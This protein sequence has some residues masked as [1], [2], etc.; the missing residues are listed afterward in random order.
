MPDMLNKTELYKH[1]ENITSGAMVVTVFDGSSQMQKIDLRTFNKNIITFGRSQEND[2]ILNS[3]IASRKHGQIKIQGKQ[4]TI[5][6]LNSTNGLI[7]KGESIKSRV[8]SNGDIIRIDDGIEPTPEGVLFIFSPSDEKDVW[9]TFTLK[10][11]DSVTIGRNTSCQIVLEHIT[12]SKLHAKIVKTDNE[13]Y[14]HDNN[15]TNGIIING[16]KVEGKEKLHEKD[17]II[18]TNSKLIFTK[19]SISYCCFVSGIEIIAQNIKKVV[20]KK[21]EKGLIKKKEKVVICN[22][23]S[24]TINPCE[25]VAII[26]GSGAGKSTIMNCISGYDVPTDGQVFVNGVNLYEN[27]E[28][29]K[30]IIGYVPQSDIVYD[31]LTI[32]DMLKYTVN[33]R[34]PNDTS[35]EEKINIIED[36]INT[37]EL[38]PHKNK[39]IKN[40]SGGQRKRAS[41]AVEMLAN[42]NLFFL[43]EPASGL[44]PGTERNLMTTLK[45]MA[46]GGKTIVLVTHS[47]LNLHICDKIIF[48]GSGGNL[49][50]YGSYQEALDFFGVDDIVNIYNMITE[51]SDEWKEKF[52]IK[53]SASIKTK[54]DGSNK[55]IS[56]TKSRKNGLRQ[57]FILCRRYIHLLFN[58][59]RRLTMILLQAPLLALLISFVADGKQFEEY[60]MTKSL[61]FALSCSG[62]W[63][64]M[65]NSIQEVCKERTVLRREY[66][67]GLRLD[68]Y[69]LSKILVLGLLCAVQAVLIVT[70]FAISTGLPLEG[71]IWQPYIEL[72]I[73]IFLTSLSAASMGIF[74]SSLSKNADRAMTVAPLLLMPQ[75]LFSGLIF[76]L[77]GAAE[78]LS[79]ITVCRWSMEG[80]GTT[81]NLN[82]LPLK[83]QEQGLAITHEAEK[84]YDFTSKHLLSSWGILGVFVIVFSVAAGIVLKNIKKN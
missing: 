81:A 15:S 8:L 65:L 31:N 4:Y 19:E 75:I 48:M 17:V 56:K 58:D 66:M 44:D 49:C 23:V 12:V 43:D 5:E 62:F 25:L 46:V 64:G 38:T 77:S 47:T 52:K 63:I 59:K 73:T 70:T 2:I 29:F 27:F 40:L 51:K 30:N 3:S 39:L 45:S 16:K 10:G 1:G 13:Y 72:L 14:I 54:S 79:W 28:A 36:V 69:I 33:L 84:F 60:E 9:H 41:I 68:A 34:L 20:L 24:I 22:D 42:P 53:Q 74:V 21:S 82:D 78:T 35:E 32:F 6:D 50:F 11:R 61:L 26:G 83:L 71:I 57:F 76:T 7:F 18:I 67:T 37:V 80:F 55:S